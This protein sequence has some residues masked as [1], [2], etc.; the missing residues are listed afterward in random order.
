M[1]YLKRISFIFSALVAIIHGQTPSE[2]IPA[3]PVFGYSSLSDSI[4][5]YRVAKKGHIQSAFETVISIDSVGIITKLTTKPLFSD[6]LTKNELRYIV[7]NVEKII[8]TTKWK[9]AVLKG[10]KVNSTISIPF[11][12]LLKSNTHNYNGAKDLVENLAGG[13]RQEPII[14]ISTGEMMWICK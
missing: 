4:S 2:Y 7:E 3:Q 11:I 10:T 14:K 5:Y 6:S 13:L 12:F 8:R 9:P 1:K